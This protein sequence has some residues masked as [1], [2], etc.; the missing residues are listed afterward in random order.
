MTT[1]ESSRTYQGT[2]CNQG[3]TERYVSSRCCAPCTI[4]RA[5]R[6][7]ALNRDEVIRQTTAWKRANPERMREI[8]RKSMKVRYARRM[9]AAL[10]SKGE[11]CQDCGALEN[12][13]FHHR[14]PSSKVSAVTAMATYPEDAFWAEVAKC[15]LLCRSCH[16]EA[17]RRLRAVAA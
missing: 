6:R 15:D 13:D 8:H 17:H 10:Q 7:Y 1:N 5:K 3:H 16:V 14:D 9:T 12:L 2:P 4:E 11:C